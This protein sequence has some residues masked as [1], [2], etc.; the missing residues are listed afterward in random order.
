MHKDNLKKIAK[1]VLVKT[2]SKE[3]I[4]I[5]LFDGA[6]IY[7]LFDLVESFVSSKWDQN[8]VCQ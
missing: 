1:L 3:R 2:K 5:T 6:K 8:T 7:R 4:W